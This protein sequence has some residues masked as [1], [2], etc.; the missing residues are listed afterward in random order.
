MKHTGPIVSATVCMLLV[1]YLADLIKFHSNQVSETVY[2]F[3]SI[4]FLFSLVFYLSK[5]D[6]QISF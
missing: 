3:T 5:A 4:S 1:F 6:K 2:V